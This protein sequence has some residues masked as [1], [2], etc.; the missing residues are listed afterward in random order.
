MVQNQKIDTLFLKSQ[1]LTVS[2]KLE[3]LEEQKTGRYLKIRSKKNLK[4]FLGGK[5]S[6][7]NS[8]EHFLTEPHPLKQKTFIPKTFLS[9]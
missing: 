2:R 3:E 5:N 9:S 6:H 1:F 8:R 7:C 4:V